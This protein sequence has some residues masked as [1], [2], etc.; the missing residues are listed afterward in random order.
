LSDFQD[1]PDITKS[2][3]Y[4]IAYTSEYGQFG[5]QPW[6]AMISNFDFGPDRNGNPK[7]PT[8][9]QLHDAC[10]PGTYDCSGSAVPWHTATHDLHCAALCFWVMCR[11]NRYK[12]I[13][14]KS[15]QITGRS[16]TSKDEDFIHSI[17][18]YTG[19]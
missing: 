4:K 15:A 18:A 1:S 17:K 6:G 8:L 13:L 14:Q 3:L 19:V 2:G 9:K 11:D 10:I 5:G 16:F 12:E 7:A